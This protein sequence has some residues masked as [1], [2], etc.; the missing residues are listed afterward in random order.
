MQ[1]EAADEARDWMTRAE[2][3]LLIGQRALHVEPILA[4]QA[5]YH[6]QQAAEKALKFQA[7]YWSRS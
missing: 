5:A 1:P 7:V 2:R 4:D 6:A 3:D